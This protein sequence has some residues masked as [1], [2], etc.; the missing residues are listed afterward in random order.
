MTIPQRLRG[1]IRQPALILALSMHEGVV[2]EVR[3]N[4]AQEL[5]RLRTADPVYSDREGHFKT[6]GG[7]RTVRS[8]AVYEENE[9]EVLHEHL[10]KTQHTIEPF[11]LRTQWHEAWV[12]APAPITME[13]KKRLKPLF[14]QVARTAVINGNVT[15][16]TPLDL[17][18]RIREHI[19]ASRPSHPITPLS[20]EADKLLNNADGLPGR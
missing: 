17:L 4:G 2:W 11:L 15:H 10:V 18:E 1:T 14:R 20:D 6:R 12:F 5:A 13:L 16:E 19:E 8:G 7:G 9:Q 3:E